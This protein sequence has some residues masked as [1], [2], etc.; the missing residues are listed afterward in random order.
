MADDSRVQNVIITDV[1]DT[2]IPFLLSRNA[3]KRAKT[4]LSSENDSVTIVGKE[5]PLKCTLICHY[6]IP[7]TRPPPDR[8]MFNQILFIKEITK[9][10]R[11]ENI[12]I[13]TKLH[14]HFS[15]PSSKKL[16]DLEMQDSGILI[17]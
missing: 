5:V 16:C 11:S 13:I 1:V 9:K 8:D 6:H 4:C 15:H 10:T 17:L 3:M 12:K 2:D 7:I 14:R